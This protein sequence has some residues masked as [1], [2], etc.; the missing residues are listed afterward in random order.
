VE[1]ALKFFLWARLSRRTRRCVYGLSFIYEWRSPPTCAASRRHVY[2]HPMMLALHAASLGRPRF[3][4][5][6]LP[7]HMWVPVP[8][9]PKHALPWR[10]SQERKKVAPKA[11]RLRGDLPALP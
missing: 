5:A 6:V 7:F 3:K 11:A 4:I 10:G 9:R 2:G 1:A 8:T